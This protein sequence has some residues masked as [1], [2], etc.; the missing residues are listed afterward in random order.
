M[1]TVFVPYLGPS[2]NEIYGGMH[3]T[4]RAKHAKK[5]H[6]AAALAMRGIEKIQ[7]PVSLTFQPILG[8]GTTSRDCSNY[9]YAVKLIEDGIVRAGVIEDDS[10]KYVTS[11]TILAPVRDRAR[12]NGMIVSIKE[13]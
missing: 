13:S 9:A 1:I 11:V 5:G 8:K 2:L 4:K 10:P 6:Y 3:W 12:G 7:H